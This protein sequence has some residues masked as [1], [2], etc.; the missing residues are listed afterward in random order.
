MT[1]QKSWR[2][3]T[4]NRQILNANLCCQFIAKNLILWS[5]LLFV[6]FWKIKFF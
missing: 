4:N 2:Y 5:K 1:Y 3:N 6:C